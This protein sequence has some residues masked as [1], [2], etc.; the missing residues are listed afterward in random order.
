MVTLFVVC[1][2][3]VIMV[4]PWSSSMTLRYVITF[5]FF[6]STVLMIVLYKVDR[7]VLH[8]YAYIHSGFGS[9]NLCHIAD[10]GFF[11]TMEDQIV[12][13]AEGGNTTLKAFRT[14][15]SIA[16]EL[17]A[18]PKLNVN[19]VGYTLPE[20]LQELRDAIALKSRFH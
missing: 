9:Y 11:L 13:D 2:G 14:G 6:N 17:L 7:V 12:A 3:A 19:L 5:E 15:P 18:K 8:F 1:A 4:I 10:V 20:R 16:T